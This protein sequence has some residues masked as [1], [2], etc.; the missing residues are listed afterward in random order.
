MS[1]ATQPYPA[2]RAR[3]QKAEDAWSDDEE[4]Q[5]SESDSDADAGRGA[6]AG[7]GAPP[8]RRRNADAGPRA[9]GAS[10]DGDDDGDVGFGDGGR[11]RRFERGYDDADDDARLL[12]VRLHTRHPSRWPT[13]DQVCSLAVPDIVT[14]SGQATMPHAA[15]LCIARVYDDRSGARITGAGGLTAFVGRC[16]RAWLSFSDM[17]VRA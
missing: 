11:E 1:A 3:R 9:R 2:G 15:Q 10:D 8:D 6:D 7:A 14:N 16:C 4:A 17:G 5:L 13:C 12:G